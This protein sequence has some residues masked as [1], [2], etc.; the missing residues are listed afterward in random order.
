MTKTPAWR[1]YLRFWRPDIAGDVD[2]EL[3]F[4]VEMR[5]EEYVAR[6]M[7]EEEARCAVTER[8]GNVDA[9]RAECIELGHVRE[10]HARRA[11]FI[12]GLR[13]D[14]RFALRSLARSPAWTT[15]ALLTI[16]LGVGATTTVFRVADTLLV[17]P[18][19]YP[20]ASRVFM[21]HRVWMAGTQTIPSGL[22]FGIARVWR[23]R[24]GTI[25]DAVFAG[26][27]SGSFG[28]GVDTVTVI[29]ANVDPEFFAFAGA[30][31]LIGRVPK[32]SEVTPDA[33]LLYLTEQFWRDRYGADPGMVGRIVHYQGDAYTIVGVVPASLSIPDFR[34]ERAA[35]M[36]LHSP[37]EGANGGVLV[38]LR[39]GVSREAA[40]Q[41]LDA[42]MRHAGLPDLR[43]VPMPMPLRLTR[44][45]DWLAIR[46]PLVMLTGAVALLLLVAC[47][48]VA[49][50]LLA[51]GAARQ[52]ELA[53][54][55][56]LGAGR[57]RLVRQ[58]ATESVVIALGGGALA[59]A[60]G[61]A[62]LRLLMALRPESRDFNALTYV[63]ADHGV[64]TI[65]SAL[66]IGCGLVIGV[67]AALRSAHRHLATS[68][69]LG[70][71]SAMSGARQL[72]S[73]LVVGEVAL[74][75]IL[76]VGALL[77]IHAVFDLQRTD[78]GFD[79]HDLYAVSIRTPREMAP[80]DRA[81]IGA[82]ARERIAASP[83][84]SAAIVTGRVPGTRGWKMIAAYETPEHPIAPESATEDVDTYAVPPDYFQMLRMPLVAGRTFGTASLAANE[85]IVSRSL[86]E[87][88]APD[89]SVI[90]MRIRNAVVRSRG[91]I[92]SIPGEPPKLVPDEPWQTVIGVVPDVTT[93][94]VGDSS[95]AIYRSLALAD[96]A[97]WAMPD[98]TIA[99]RANGDDAVARLRQL[100]TSIAGDKSAVEIVNVRDEID[101]SLA[102]P[103]F[104][105]R[106]LVA[107][108]VV[109]VLLA[110]LGLYGVI[111]YNVGQRTREIGVRLAI[112]ATRG[113]I[114]RLVIG[115]GIRLALVG[116]VLG[117]IGS[118]AAA[119]LIQGVLYG[120]PRLDPFSLGVGAVVMLVVS[121]AAC[122]A[123]MLRA[124]ALDPVAA[125]RLE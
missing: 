17:R 7:S 73:S 121:M 96:T 93:S 86:A 33:R 74:S 24:A 36:T 41:E 113:A 63:S 4:H 10:R 68:L 14:V 83:N 3:R 94:R 95:P 70:A 76:L 90:G 9:A 117:L 50:L 87:Q 123:P 62:G 118:I 56:A 80:A 66:A 77:L 37:M 112:G 100:A 69:R 59:V 11:S 89:G 30:H 12:D 97:G 115:D 60:V 34:S 18:F 26:H 81:A 54:R 119:R 108:A 101:A 44:P 98:V 21:A 42:I 40:T 75:A 79:A 13:S 92:R 120:V 124:T 8:L 84:V 29:S 58:L 43:P 28:T 125:I 110:A 114:A 2:D 32:T 65:A 45:E 5:V 31:P 53:V 22:P 19:P 111:S 61:W 67:A 103:R 16:A 109:G 106:I 46:K 15:V 38:R 1:R 49:H 20:N 107:F 88:I 78:L 99:A 72:R 57:A 25:E 64:L 71:S 51:R 91:G 105:M 104:I 85:V 23:E 52:R 55:H 82:A 47:T 39:P 35:V 116:I 122:V 27:G 48:N 102:E 6:G